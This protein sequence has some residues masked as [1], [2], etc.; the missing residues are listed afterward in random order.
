MGRQVEVL[1]EGRGEDGRAHGRTRQNRVTWLERPASPGE[2]VT[3]RVTA[4]SAWQLVA[5]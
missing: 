5:A 3:A 1:V 4:T 2:V